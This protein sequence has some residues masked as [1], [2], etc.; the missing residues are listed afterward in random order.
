MVSY[1]YINSVNQN[2][3][4]EIMKRGIGILTFGISAF[5]GGLIAGLL[6]T[7]KSGKENRKWLSQ[8]GQETRNW[9]EDRGKKI[10]QDSEKRIDRV[11]EGI[12]KTV[13]NTVPD[14]YEATEN[15]HFSEEDQEHA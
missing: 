8:H 13:K 4:R 11:S 12:R 6:I 2:Q 15:L 5:A 3:K 1:L 9:L 7:P 14:L 10:K